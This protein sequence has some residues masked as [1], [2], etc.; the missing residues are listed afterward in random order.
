VSARLATALTGVCVAA[1][2]ATAALAASD[3]AFDVANDR[4]ADQVARAVVL[5]EL[6]EDVRWDHDRLVGLADG[7]TDDAA[8][9]TVVGPPGGN[10]RLEV[11]SEPLGRTSV[12]CLSD[13]GDHGAVVEHGPCR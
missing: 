1:A 13:D 4:L 7:L 11:T 12:R 8:D 6:D 2:G 3:G 9:V 10:A 5:S